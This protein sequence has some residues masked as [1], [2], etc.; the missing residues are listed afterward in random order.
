MQHMSLFIFLDY[1][2]RFYFL[3]SEHPRGM[4]VHS[5]CGFETVTTAY[6]GRIA[7]YDSAGNSGVIGEG[8]VQWMKAAS[9][10]LHKEYHEAEFG[11]QG[12]DFHMV[13]LW[14]NLPERFKMSPPEYQAITRDRIA[15]HALSDGAGEVH[16]IAGE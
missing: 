16:I 2:S 13:Q 3:P 15:R 11:T 1:N 4:G 10:V 8:E 12:G 7:H 9:G 14:V 6:K 5:H